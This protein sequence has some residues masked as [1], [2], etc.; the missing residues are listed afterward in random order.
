MTVKFPVPV[1]CPTPLILGQTIDRCIMCGPCLRVVLKSDR[2]FFTHPYMAENSYMN[3]LWYIFIGKYVHPFNAKISRAAATSHLNYK[4][5][6]VSPAP[7]ITGLL[8]GGGG[9]HPNHLTL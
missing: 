8:Q 1:G 2:G 3:S 5:M 4:A 9:Y 7:C 6:S